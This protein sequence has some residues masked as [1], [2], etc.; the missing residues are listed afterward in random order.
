MDAYPPAAGGI[1]SALAVR[2]RADPFNLVATGIFFLAIAHTFLAPQFRRWARAAEE[3]HLRRPA[4][5]LLDDDGNPVAEVS[6]AGQVLHLLGEVEAVF[7]VWAVVLGVAIGVA[8]GW[9]VARDYAGSR[10]FTEPMFVMVI[11][12]LVST[13]PLLRLAEHCLQVFAGLGGATLGAW[14]AAILIVGPLLGSFISE[15]GAMTISALLLAR[16]FY[17]YEPSRRLSYATMGLLFVNVSVGGALTPFAAPP[18]VMA[19]GPW[20]WNL[21]FMLGH[22]GWRAALGIMTATATYYALFRGEFRELNRKYARMGRQLTQGGGAYIPPWIF[23]VHV[24]FVAFVVAVARYPALFVGA[25]LF[26]LAFAQATG[27]VQKKIDLRGPLLVA[28]FLSG[29][30]VHGGLQ[31]W[32]LQPVLAHLG[33]MPLFLGATFLTSFNDN[34]AITYLATLV[35]G[36]TLGLK[37]A[38]VAGAVTGGGLTVIANAPN[39][40]GQTLLQRFFPEGVSPWGLMA[41][42]LLPTVILAVAFMA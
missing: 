29:L 2:A 33:R 17:H 5:R 35:P 27:H 32:W 4:S 30:V 21:A 20:H 11:M 36:L 24:A 6:F 10:D 18:M 8:K 31:S 13:R 38:V 16:Q 37:Y 14:W 3:R 34:A 28:F 15:P 40:A 7:G 42:A 26:F 41:G 22:F 23:L 1:W 39:P 25:F 12:A 19:A 9:T